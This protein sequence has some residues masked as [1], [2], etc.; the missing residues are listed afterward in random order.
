VFDAK[1]LFT[2][3]EMKGLSLMGSLNN[4]SS[5]VMVVMTLVTNFGIRFTRILLEAEMLFFLR[6]KPLKILK[7]KKSQNMLLMGSLM[8]SLN[9]LPQLLIMRE[10]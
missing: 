4:V 2:S 3:L 7:R 1:N 6:T 8:L 5:L 9:L 10:M